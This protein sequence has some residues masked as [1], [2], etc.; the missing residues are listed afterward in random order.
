MNN[1]K[2][3]RNYIHTPL[4]LALAFLGLIWIAW[5]GYS[6]VK[7]EQEI[8]TSGDPAVVLSAFL[9]SIQLKDLTF[10]KELATTRL[11]AII[12]QWTLDAHHQP[13]RCTS[14][15]AD[16]F[17]PRWRG[18]GGFQEVDGTATGFYLLNC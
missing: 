9:Q 4:A 5:L 15:L 2:Q 11:A 16:Y 6:E 8:L 1:L 7:K 12:D 10:A 13:H 18:G 14:D 17:E 3:L